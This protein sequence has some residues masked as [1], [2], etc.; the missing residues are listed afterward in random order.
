[1]QIESLTEDGETVG[2]KKRKDTGGSFKKNKKR[3][4][5]KP[6]ADDEDD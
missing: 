5:R 6:I 2:F 1:M 4:V 3:A